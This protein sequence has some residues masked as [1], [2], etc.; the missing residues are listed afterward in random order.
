MNDYSQLGCFIDKEKF[1]LEKKQDI[2]KECLLHELV[3]CEEVARSQVLFQ[4]IDLTEKKG[5]P[6]HGL[7]SLIDE[8]IYIFL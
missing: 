2:K 6:C 3:Y 8:G 4:T 7:L 5:G 1:W